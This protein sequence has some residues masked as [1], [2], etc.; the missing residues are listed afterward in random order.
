MA[1]A[2]DVRRVMATAGALPGRIRGVFHAAGVADLRYLAELSHDVSEREFGPKIYGVLNLERAIA[3]SSNK[4]DFVVLFSSMAS[5]LGGLAMTA[6]AA[7]NRFMD[8]FAQADPVRNGVSWISVNWDDWDFD[9][10]VEQ[11]AAYEKTQAQYAMTPAEGVEALERI[12]ACGRPTQM[13]V[14]TRPLPERMARWL[15]QDATLRS[16]ISSEDSAATEPG[17]D[18]A[19]PPTFEQRIASVYREVLGLTAIGEDDNFFDLGGDSLLAA[20]ILRELRRQFPETAQ[21][22]LQAVFDHPTAREMARHLIEL[23]DPHSYHEPMTAAGTV[24]D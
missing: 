1:S 8:A 14:A 3:T 7:A 24:G 2:D 22:Q 13:L 12:L 15:D 19:E 11:T 10:T 18:T 17:A 20:Q 9:Y 6:Y 16:S 21:P 5:I 4:P 23:G